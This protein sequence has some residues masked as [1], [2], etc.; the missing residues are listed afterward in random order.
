MKWLR[1]CAV[2]LSFIMFSP[3]SHAGQDPIGWSVSGG[4]PAQTIPNLV[5]PGV[6][7]TFI[8]NMPFQMVTPLYIN[9]KASPASQF[10][11]IDGCSGLR[12][13]PGATCTVSFTFS[14]NTTGPKSVQLEEDYGR[15]VVPLPILTS[16][17][18]SGPNPTVTGTVTIPLPATMPAGATAPFQ[19]TYK[20]TN[21]GTVV[22]VTSF[23]VTINPNPGGTGT[24]TV[25]PGNDTC[26]LLPFNQLTP[27]QSCTVTGTFTAGIVGTY[28]L[29]HHITYFPGST[30]I[31]SLSTTTNAAQQVTGAVTTPLPNPMGAGEQQPFKF[32]FT[33]NGTSPIIIPPLSTATS[34][35]GGTTSGISDL[36][37]GTILA[38]NGGTCTVSGTFNSQLPGNYS[39]TTV[40][41]LPGGSTVTVTTTSTGSVRVTGAPT[42]PLPPAMGA[43]ETR[44]I[45]FTF[46]N[47]GTGT[48][49]GVA[50]P[51]H[52]DVGGTFVPDAAIAGHCGFTSTIAAGGSCI[53][54]GDFTSGGP[55][56]YSV[57]AGFNYAGGTNVAQTTT[58]STG[59]VLVVGS[60][61]QP[62]PN[63]MGTGETDHIAFKFTN[64]GTGTITGV[65][66][67]S[68]TEVGGTFTP[69]PV[70]AGQCGF[71]STIAAGGSCIYSG[72]FTSGAGPGPF[73]VT[74]GFNYA[75]GTNVAQVTTSSATGSV[76]VVGT[77]TQPLPDPM[78][79][80]ERQPFTF[81]F[82]NTG[83][84]IANGPESLTVI[85]T[86]GTLNGVVTDN[87]TA[88]FPL[89]PGDSCTVTGQ[90]DSGAI[91]TTTGCYKVQASLHYAGGTAIVSTSSKGPEIL[92]K[93]EGTPPAF[94]PALPASIG[95][96]EEYTVA[97]TYVNTGTGTA[98]NVSSPAFFQLV[99][100]I[101]T[102]VTLAANCPLSFP[103][104]FAPG[105]RCTAIC[106]N[107]EATSPGTVSV[108]S[109]IN[110]DGGATPIVTTSASATVKVVADVPIPLPAASSTTTTYPI[111]FRFT[112]TGA[113]AVDGAS[114]TPPFTVSPGPQ[115]QLTLPSYSAGCTAVVNSGQAC[116]ASVT[117]QPA[118]PG[119][120]TVFATYTYDGGV[121]IPSTTTTA[122]FARKLTINNYCGTDVWFSFNGAPARKG[123]S[124][125][126]PCAQGSTCNKDADGGKGICY[127]TN[128][129]PAKGGLH[130]GPM[131]E[132]K[133]TTTSILV[134]DMDAKNTTIWSGSI[135]GR[136]GC[137]GKSCETAD[138]DSSGG[139]KS[140]PPGNSFKLPATL[141]ELTLMRSVEDK[142]S[143]Q[144]GNGI[145]LSMSMGPT[146][147]DK[148]TP[149]YNSSKPYYCATPGSADASRIFNA[150][151]WMLK[152]PAYPN[153]SSAVD[154][155][156][157]KPG[158][159]GACSTNACPGS[160]VCGLSFG[161]GKFAKVCGKQIGY[162][163]ANQAC[164]LNAVDASS[165]F[166]CKSAMTQPAGEV[167]QDLNA[168]TNASPQG[169]NSQACTKAGN[170]EKA[171][172]VQW[173]KSACPSV[174][175]FAG[176]T[177]NSSFTCKTDEPESKVKT[178]NAN[179]KMNVTDYTISF[180]PEM[181]PGSQFRNL[182]GAASRP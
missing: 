143:I 59:T 101:C 136:T 56:S 64:M 46:T 93:A 91:C 95:T 77:A 66:A 84:G 116:L 38:A 148:T 7:Y 27:G 89:A 103:A 22:N 58:S 10:T 39:V 131:T 109:K 4:L 121:L 152:P 35:V 82:T 125:K 172:M 155:V 70:V 135:A 12:L 20:N 150:C 164:L 123:C 100:G 67:P 145:N 105:D 34:S 3:V 180:C 33:N 37:S 160:E 92:V 44:H 124:D 26:A 73:S 166:D 57:T 24:V 90:F 128:P 179:M 31:T 133:P 149:A 167:L 161:D 48:I 168:C 156:W 174:S 162:W 43:G 75:G 106:N 158:T 171:A 32:T 134:P 2:M 176:D 50:V 80:G 87:C 18:V 6:T 52:T 177:V 170:K 53:Y 94:F 76:L 49:Y 181:A 21:N 111:T 45:V 29:H 14:F 122:T 30:G 126:N 182:R 163:T 114:T 65:T 23:P 13:M 68:H 107:F 79:A 96:G 99:G 8:N 113:R 110:T 19:F 147:P 153:A 118:A 36:C 5:Y 40:L 83:S 154:Y 97:I 16:N 98:L 112:N 17:T 139:D 42:T 165:Y 86:G 157:V 141:A 62:L 55:G 132:L 88:A 115:T 63:P 151:S 119:S 175:A 127:F 108:S 11:F 178:N 47:N 25:L 81:T 117:F 72:N 102:S 169:A 71:T 120:Y 142:Y 9:K 60:V 146:N 144:A 41:T 159:G 78:G 85:T 51:T 61:T 74:A 173:I 54:S 137:S 130:L 28:T 1:Y 138:C 140:C 129:L 104:D 15:N 69:D